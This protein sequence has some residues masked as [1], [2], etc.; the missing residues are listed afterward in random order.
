MAWPLEVTLDNDTNPVSRINGSVNCRLWFPEF[1][2]GANQYD[3][4]Y[5]SRSSQPGTMAVHGGSKTCGTELRFQVSKVR[6]VVE[7]QP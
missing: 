7:Y 6:D 5:D 3:W 2:T 1:G 4:R